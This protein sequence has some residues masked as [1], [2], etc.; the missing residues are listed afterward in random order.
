[1]ADKNEDRRRLF[2]CLN[3]KT[4]TMLV[5][6][7]RCVEFSRNSTLYAFLHALVSSGG[8][9]NLEE[10]VQRVWKEESY[11]P[12]RL[13]LA[14]GKLRKAIEKSPKDPQLLMTV[15]DGYELGGAV[16]IRH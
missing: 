3:P 11:H 7:G 8:R 6:D 9:M 14:V 15:E 13:R 1:M 16:A 10:I 2:W 4:Y 5:S 12:L